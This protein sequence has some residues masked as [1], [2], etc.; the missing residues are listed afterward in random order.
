LVIFS[1]GGLVAFPPPAKPDAKPDYDKLAKETADAFG[2]CLVK[3][4]VDGMVKLVEFPLIFEGGEKKEKAEDLR[5]EF[6]NFPKDEFAK[7]KITVK[8]SVAPNKFV[9][10]GKKLPKA[11]RIL[12]KD[13]QLKAILE[14]VGKDGRIVALEAERAGEKMDRL[15]LIFVKFKDD[16][17]W[18][19]GL[20]E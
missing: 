12:D 18:V 13:D 15:G 3:L 9:E 4:D 1:T 20:A 17:P 2:Q 6:A 10:W 8:E 5:A 7:M 14:R 19:V 16:K 11:P